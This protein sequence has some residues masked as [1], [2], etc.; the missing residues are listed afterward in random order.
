MAIVSRARSG[1]GRE[2]PEGRMPLL[3]HLR[4]LRNRLLKAF[5]AISLGAVVG[6]VYYDPIFEFLTAPMEQVIEEAEAAGQTVTLVISGIGQPFVLQMQVA[7][8][9]GLVLSAPLWIYQLWAFV[10]PGLHRKER[11]YTLLFVGAATPLFLA[12][13]AVGYLVLP[14]ALSLLLG[15]TPENLSNLPTINEYLSFVIRMLLVFGLGFLA[16]LFVVSLNL[17]GVLSAENLRKTWRWTV[18]GVFLFAA[19]AT[20]TGDPITMGL[21]AAPILLLMGIAFGIAYLNDRRRARRSSEPDYDD[22]DDD[23]ASPIGTPGRIEAPSAIEDDDPADPH[24]DR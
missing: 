1:R 16:P 18:L 4:E 14:K 17:V 2:E 24:P 15:F 20:P 5:L 19:V 11:R 3:D 13:M 6:W 23:A 10:T 21:L 22:L 7:A 9:V 8:V 12:G